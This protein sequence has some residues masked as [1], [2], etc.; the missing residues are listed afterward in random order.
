MASVNL[1]SLRHQPP[2]LSAVW[3]VQRCS[4]HRNRSA[5]TL[6]NP[7]NASVTGALNIRPSTGLQN[8]DPIEYI[9]LT[10]SLPIESLDPFDEP[11]VGFGDMQVHIK[12]SAPRP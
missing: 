5:S 2:L 3:R 12:G 4:A 9:D 1:D 6:S 11:A 8:Y 7:H 10:A